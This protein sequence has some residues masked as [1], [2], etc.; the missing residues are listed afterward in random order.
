MQLEELYQLYLKSTGVSTDTRHITER[1][2]FFALKGDRFNG[3]HWAEQALDNGASYV[4]LDEREYLKDDRMI[5]VDDVLSCLQQLAGFHRQQYKNPVI[6]LTGSNG[7]TTTKEL[8]HLILTVEHDVNTTV[9]NFNNHIGLPLT[10]LKGSLEQDFWLVE[11]GTNSPGEIE[12]LC[13][14]AQPNF[15]LITNIGAAHLEKLINLDGVYQEKT[16]LFRS[17]L[18]SNGS[19]FVNRGDDYLKSF[20]TAKRSITY[21]TDSCG[22]GDLR[23]KESKSHL[24]FELIDDQGGLHEFKS[25]LVGRYNQDNI[26]A[27]LTVGAYFG[28]PIESAIKAINSYLPDNM[29][30]QLKQTDHNLL[31]LDT[32]NANPTSMKASILSFIQSDYEAPL[33]I[34]GDM[35]ESGAQ[36]LDQHKEIEELLIRFDV[37]YYLVGHSFAAVSDHAFDHVDSLKAYLVDQGL[38]KNKTVLLKA[39]RGIALERLLDLL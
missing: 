9:G 32:Y 7:K 30:S 39:S 37:P 35:L 14:I 2:L 29:R 24:Y 31:V 21:T 23:L 33:C 8:I 10:L 15:G 38:I 4:I 13:E 11:M 12:L 20:D 34:I 17:V 3:N 26:S 22:F 16:S 27:A 1:Q 28:V 5:L 18:A 6:G 36:G 25:N 19:I